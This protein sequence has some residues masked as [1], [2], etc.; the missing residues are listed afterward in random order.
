MLFVEVLFTTRL[1]RIDT[2]ARYVELEN[3][4]DTLGLL[5]KR[6]QGLIMLPGITEIGKSWAMCWRL[7]DLRRPASPGRWITR[8]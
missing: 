5:L 1:V 8:T 7:S 3:F 6:N 4:R 2:F